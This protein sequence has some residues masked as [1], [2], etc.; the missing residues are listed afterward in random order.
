MII[1][2]NF[3]IE[4][5]PFKTYSLFSG[6]ISA[7]IHHGVS[8]TSCYGVAVAGDGT[9]VAYGLFDSLPDEHTILNSSQFTD[10]FDMARE[11]GAI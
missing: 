5:V 10:F 3:E 4:D 6:K 9:G 7:D 8:D 11:F 1:L 2:D